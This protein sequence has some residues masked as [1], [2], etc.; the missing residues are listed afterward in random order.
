[1]KVE[2]GL[3]SPYCEGIKRKQTRE[4][5]T[6]IHAWYVVLPKARNWRRRIPFLK[7]M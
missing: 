2:S 7:K 3:F 6:I 1:M 5:G 4:G